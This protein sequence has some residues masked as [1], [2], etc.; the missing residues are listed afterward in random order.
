MNS[1]RTR[2]IL[3]IL[4]VVCTAISLSCSAGGGPGK[5]APLSAITDAQAHSKHRIRAINS[6]WEK[7][8]N[9]EIEAEMLRELLK[10]VVWSRSTF[11]EIRMAALKVLVADTPRLDDTRNMITLLLATETHWEIMEYIADIASAR[12]WRDL[13]PG[14]VR[15]WAR[16][17][18]V[19]PSDAD[20]PERRALAALFPEQSVEET[21]YQVFTARLGDA[22]VRERDR[23]AAWGLLCRIDKDTTATRSILAADNEQTDDPMLRVLRRSA[24]ELK[25]VPKSDEQLRWLISLAGE[26]HAAVWSRAAQEIGGLSG[27][28]LAGFELRHVA[29]VVWASGHEAAWLSLDRRGLLSAL[30]TRLSEAETHQRVRNSNADFVR[31]ATV[32]EHRDELAWGDALSALIASEFV[33]E[34]SLYDAIF[35]F[36]HRDQ[37]DRSTEYGGAIGFS[38]T[39]RFSMLEFPPRPAQRIADNRFVASIDLLDASDDALF[40]FHNH[41]QRFRNATY[42]GPSA[43][44][45]EYA[46]RE[47]RGCLVFTFTDRDTLNV[48]YYQGNGVVLDLGEIR[49]PGA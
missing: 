13:A 15:S 34:A 45:I 43:G 24:N 49:R 41:A 48:D 46:A 17:P 31:P 14:L 40:H 9:N 25:A 38:D 22:S 4:L 1:E 47:G 39:S 19:E 26:E 44:D 21:V 5:A 6:S 20:R 2:P 30:E 12:G 36:A 23:L 35:H 7:V 42:A 32:K 10:R 8:V 28:Q 37:L 3:V 27:E 33:H 11:W 18:V 29:A 16:P